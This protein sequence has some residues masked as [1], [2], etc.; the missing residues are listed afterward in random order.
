ML[1]LLRCE[2]A[3]LRRKPLFFAAAAVSALIPLAYALFLPDFKQFTSSREAVD[4]MMA[5]LFQMSAC[6]LLMPALVNSPSPIPPSIVT[7]AKQ[8]G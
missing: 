5:A 7:M 1:K 4:S 8:S 6:L 3:K 2:L